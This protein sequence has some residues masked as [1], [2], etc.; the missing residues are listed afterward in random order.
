[1]D[2][3]EAVDV[4]AVEEEA[5][6][7]DVVAVA[8]DVVDTVEGAEE[9]TVLLTLATLLE[10]SSST[11]LAALLVSLR[12]VLLDVRLVMLLVIDEVPLSSE[13]LEQALIPE[14]TKI[15]ARIGTR[16]RMIFE[17][18]LLMDFFFTLLSSL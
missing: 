7:V 9:T 3:T 15:T 11:R 5:V 10:P 17:L 18:L 6:V 1:M 2:A 14:I 4:T 12:V 16:Y 8:R 13:P